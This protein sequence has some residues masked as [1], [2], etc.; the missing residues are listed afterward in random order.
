MNC[1]KVFDI[2]N[3]SPEACLKYLFVKEYKKDERISIQTSCRTH[4]HAD[5]EVCHD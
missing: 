1:A 2:A 4:Q 3:I 5:L